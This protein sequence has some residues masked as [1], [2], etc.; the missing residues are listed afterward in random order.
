MIISCSATR[1]EIDWYGPR[2][3]ST[4][5]PS[6]GATALVIGVYLA[7]GVSAGFHQ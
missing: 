3:H 5:V 7:N 6:C 1:L 4:Y 2:R